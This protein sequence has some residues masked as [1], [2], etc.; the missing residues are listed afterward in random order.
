MDI[1]HIAETILEDGLDDWVPLHSLAW[2][3][4]DEAAG[5]GDRPRDVLA[6]ALGFLLEQKLVTVGDLGDRIIPWQG[7]VPS[8]VSRVV[9]QCDELD[10][11]PR[12]DG[13]WFANTDKGN[14]W[15]RSRQR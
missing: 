5:S 14:A 13:C 10:W 6:A 8:V 4:Q 1:P 2:A 15:I 3:A 7:D 9:R 12:G 11:N